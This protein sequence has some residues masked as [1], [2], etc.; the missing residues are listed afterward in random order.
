MAIGWNFCVKGAYLEYV[1]KSNTVWHGMSCLTVCSLTSSGFKKIAPSFSVTTAIPSPLHRV[2]Y[3]AACP[4]VFFSWILLWTTVAVLQVAF[5]AG[6]KNFSQQRCKVLLVFQ[7]SWSQ[8]LQ[9]QSFPANSTIQITRSKLALS[10]Y[11]WKRMKWPVSP[12]WCIISDL[13]QQQW[14]NNLLLLGLS[15]KEPPASFLQRLV[16]LN[17]A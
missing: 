2:P 3:R 10:C 1:I 8:Q 17:W 7:L 15:A 9:M 4:Q 14:D 11:P 5:P 13:A 12:T 6:P 16:I